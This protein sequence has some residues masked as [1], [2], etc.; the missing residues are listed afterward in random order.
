MARL[1]ESGAHSETWKL[2]TDF[3]SKKLD[4]IKERE[5]S[6]G[7]DF[8]KFDS[9]FKAIKIFKTEFYGLFAL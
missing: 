4:L 6:G 7:V 1:S 9:Q 8:H 5:E 3:W 2:Y